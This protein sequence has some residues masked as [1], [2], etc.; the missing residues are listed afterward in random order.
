[1]CGINGFNFTDSELIKKMQLI[2]KNR[3]PDD[4]GIFTNENITLGHNRL[5]ILDLS[6]NGKQPMIYQNLIIS[7]NGEIYNFKELREELKIKG[8][9][10][11]SNTDTEVILYLF[12]EHNIEAFK[13][14]SGIFAISIYD[15]EEKKLYLV[16]DTVGVKPLYYYYNQ[17]KKKIFFSSSIRSLLLSI[18]KKEINLKALNFYYNFG[19][20][21]DSETIFKNIFKLLPG[22]LLIFQNNEIFKK[23]YL[24]FNFTNEEPLKNEIKTIVKENIEKQFISDVPVALS[25]SGGVDSNVI[26][27]IMRK[28]I[29]ANLYTFYFKDYDKFNEDYKVAK[30]NSDFYGYNLN[31]I[32]INYQD[33]IN[34]SEE[35]IRILEEPIANQCSVLNLAMS[36]KIKEKVL[37]TGDGGDEIFTGYDRYKSIHIINTLQNFKIFKMLGLFFDNKNARRLKINNARDMFLSFSEQNIYKDIKKNF[38]NATLIHKESLELNHCKNLDLS[39]R[40]NNV[41]FIDLDTIIPNEYLLRMDKI[42]MNRGI[43]VRVPFLDKD[44]IEKCLFVNENKKFNY[45]FNSKGLLRNIFSND[46]NSLVKKKWGLQSPLAKWMKGPLQ[47]FLK[48]I[49]SEGYYSGSKSYLNF[50][51]ISKLIIEHKKNYY[52]PELL[53]SLVNLQIFLRINKI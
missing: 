42:F 28:K 35:A 25:L 34:L 47:K 32:E 6:K 4:N 15:N 12:K 2:T 24:N 48:E 20:N 36:K 40:L 39:N 9:K 8:Y 3:G 14:L 29:A 31:L 23:K 16:R 10:F 5:S 37:F 49:L 53:W 13:K 45:N 33:F 44:I 27:S 17:N 52:N 41:A 51:E 11:K 46:V 7:Y 30:K 21:D 22:E 43:E 26:F 50:S 18:K 38:Y 19:R 1:M